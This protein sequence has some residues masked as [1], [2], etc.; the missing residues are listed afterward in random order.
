MTKLF[1]DPATFTEDMVVGFAD[2]N[3]DYV[4]AVPGGVVRA[5]PTREGQGGRDR[6]W[7][8]G[9]LSGLLPAW[10]GRASPTGR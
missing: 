3:A 2:A 7:R 4:V 5:V 9:P 6:R 1:N 8:F 10:S